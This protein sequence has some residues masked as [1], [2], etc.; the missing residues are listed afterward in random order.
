[1]GS[2]GEALDSGAAKIA[3]TAPGSPMS[4]KPNGKQ[5]VRE[6]ALWKTV[7]IPAVILV[8]GFALTWFYL[9]HHER[10]HN[11]PAYSKPQQVAAAV[12]G[13]TM[14][15]SFAV[16]TTGADADWARNNSTALETVMSEALQ[17]VQP[18]RLTSASGMQSFQEKVR[19]DVNT[20]LKTDKVQEVLVTDFLYAPEE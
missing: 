8:V 2:G 9:Q 15:L 10:L 1:M 13:Y 7:A 3:L 6:R 18:Q 20:R 4:K 19:A 11:Q 12:K 17:T 5:S 16:R 14:R